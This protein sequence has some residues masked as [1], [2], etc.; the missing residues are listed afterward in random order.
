MGISQTIFST[1][2]KIPVKQ[3]DLE[4]V[5]VYFSPQGNCQNEIIQELEEARKTVDLTMYTFTSHELC[6]ELI[7][8]KQKGVNIRVYC[9]K[10]MKTAKYSQVND[11]SNNEIEVRFD[12]HSGL[13]HN[14]FAVIDDKTVI[15]G[16]YNWTKGAENKNDENIIIIHNQ[17]VARIYSN[18]FNELWSQSC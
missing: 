8:L 5:E 11:L 13:M 12:N 15:T 3:D 1:T 4:T 9:D 10:S 7:K 14:K 2:L 18:K 17:D 16:S 6:N